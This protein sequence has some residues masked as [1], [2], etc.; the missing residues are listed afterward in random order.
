M[1]GGARK[2]PIDEAHIDIG[3]RG[4]GGMRVP[5]KTERPIRKD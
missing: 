1:E 3:R 5:L 2:R 4:G